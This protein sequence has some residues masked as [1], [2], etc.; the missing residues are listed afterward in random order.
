MYPT[1]KNAEQ[2]LLDHFMKAWS[3]HASIAQIRASESPDF[4]GM[5]T[6]G[7]RFGLEMVTVTDESLAKSRSDI[8]DRFVPE[9]QEACRAR[10][11][12]AT[13]IVGFEEWDAQGLADKEHRRKLADRL[14]DFARD[15]QPQRKT[16]YRR[17]LEASGIEGLDTLVFYAESPEDVGV[18]VTRTAWGRGSNE[19]QACIT[20]KDEKALAYRCK[21]GPEAATTENDLQVGVPVMVF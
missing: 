18:L 6:T 15:A 8:H 10:S 17:Q 2:T 3:D 14:A 5:L 9:L 12:G 19:I 4:K 11:V 16:I 13:F 21:L 1:K 20:A 7:Q